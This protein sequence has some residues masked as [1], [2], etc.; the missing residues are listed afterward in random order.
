MQKY[1]AGQIDR[2][3]LAGEIEQYWS[4]VTPVEH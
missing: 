3:A 2:A 1:L 4:T